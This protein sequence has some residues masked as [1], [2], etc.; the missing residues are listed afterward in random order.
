[1]LVAGGKP[2]YLGPSNVQGEIIID[3][4]RHLLAVAL[5]LFSPAMAETDKYAAIHTVGI[6]S[7]IGD[8]VRFRDRKT[9]Y[10]PT[11][12]WDLN[13][14][15]WKIDDL[16]VQTVTTA[17]SPRFHVMPVTVNGDWVYK[18]RFTPDEPLERRLQAYVRNMPSANS[19]DAYI[20]V[21][22]DFGARSRQGDRKW[23][24]GFQV[25]Y[26]AEVWAFTDDNPIYVDY[27]VFVFDA[28]SGKVIDRAYAEVSDNLL[29]ESEPIYYRDRLWAK[30]E[31]QFTRTQKET[32]KGVI[33]PAITST[34][35]GAL[36][37]LGL[38][39]NPADTSA[40]KQR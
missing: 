21:Q 36:N 1:M 29:E 18:G 40:Q 6:I 39:A 31:A 34:L 12:S 3:R 11:L 27:T 14:S 33:I 4:M 5:L 19:V 38:T 2:R 15:D 35:S 30:N 24:M 28:K 32:L 25:E 10:E 7:G 16:V 17:I 20:I 37:R 13:I 9:A 8:I 22:K 23:L 26:N